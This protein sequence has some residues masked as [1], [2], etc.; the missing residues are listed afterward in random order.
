MENSKWKTLKDFMLRE[1]FKDKVH[2]MIWED[3]AIISSRNGDRIR[4]DATWTLE[5][6][7]KLFKSVQQYDGIYNRLSYIRNSTLI[8]IIGTL[9]LN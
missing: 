7:E 5:E 6:V 4:V 1:E 3:H 8:T 2:K 9:F